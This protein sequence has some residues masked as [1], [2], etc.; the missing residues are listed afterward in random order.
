MVWHS[1]TSLPIW[2]KSSAISIRL[3][4][5]SV[6]TASV[7]TKKNDI[8][9]EKIGFPPIAD[10]RSEILILGSLPGDLSIRA[11]EYYA[12]PH[13]TFWRLI[14]YRPAGETVGGAGKTASLTENDHAVKNEH[15][16]KDEYPAKKR[17]LTENRIAL[18]DVLTRAE[19]EGALD[20]NIRN[21]VPN[22]FDAF[23]TAH[24]EIRHIFFNGQKAA[25]LFH[26]HVHAW[27]SRIPCTTL[28]SS[29]PANARMNFE[30]KKEVWASVF[31]ALAQT[32]GEM[33]H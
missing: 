19:R 7:M 31:S 27:E 29:S 21:E 23:L 12:N 28:P 16:V 4:R 33:D 22:D 2:K 30:Q 18:W 9:V 8:N 6:K 10:R 3:S 17:Y 14:G 11:Q 24:P 32:N 1:T 25:A 15:A 20:S 5:E 26:R 13:N